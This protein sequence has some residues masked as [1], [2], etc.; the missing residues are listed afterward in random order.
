M[1]S[2]GGEEGCCG[3]GT[4]IRRRE[5]G[6]SWGGGRGVNYVQLC[7]IFSVAACPGEHFEFVLVVLYS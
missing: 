1:L 3:L 6:G 5:G 2:G 7:K 4:K